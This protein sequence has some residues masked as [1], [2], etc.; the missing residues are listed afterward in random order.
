M[1]VSVLFLIIMIVMI[2]VIIIVII[3]FLHASRCICHF[4]RRM[5]AS[6]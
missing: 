1:F 2:I 3:L 6:L 5:G 4:D